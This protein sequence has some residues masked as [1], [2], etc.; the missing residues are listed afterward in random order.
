MR[1]YLDINEASFPVRDGPIRWHAPFA[2]IG[3]LN[4]YIAEEDLIFKTIPPILDLTQQIEWEEDEDYY[5]VWQSDPEPLDGGLWK[6]TR[7][8]A[9]V[10]PQI[11]DYEGPVSVSYPGCVYFQL[12]WMWLTA[13]D[14]VDTNDPESTPPSDPGET[15]GRW[16][17]VLERFVIRDPVTIPQLTR[18]VRTF[19]FG[20][21]PPEPTPVLIPQPNGLIIPGDYGGLLVYSGGLATAGNYVTG[22]QIVN[23]TTPS[24]EDYVL[25]VENGD[26]I[27][28]ESGVRRWQGFIW[29]KWTRYAKAQ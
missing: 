5:L 28:V 24:L 16:V 7:R 9:K 6:V 26:E 23:K 20:S 27:V 13:P 21:T 29:E 12:R 25:M 17:L 11:T 18:T 3:I 19:E 8:W 10:P 4:R 15:K 14:K 1:A 22:G 2:D